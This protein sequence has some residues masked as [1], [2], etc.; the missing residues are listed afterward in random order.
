LHFL[1]QDPEDLEGW[2]DVR[3]E[4]RQQILQLIS[5]HQESSKKE[6]STPKQSKN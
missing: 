2:E 3:A 4:D 6:T 1:K 5:D